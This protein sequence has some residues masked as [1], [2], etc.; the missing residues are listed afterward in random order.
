M[1]KLHSLIA[2]SISLCKLC[3][4]LVNS[5]CSGNEGNTFI[6]GT[7]PLLSFKLKFSLIIHCSPVAFTAELHTMVLKFLLLCLHKYVSP[8]HL[9]SIIQSVLL[10]TMCLMKVIP[11]YLLD[12][13]HSNKIYWHSLFVLCLFLASVSLYA[14][15]LLLGRRSIYLP[16]EYLIQLYKCNSNACVTALRGPAASR[17]VLLELLFTYQ[18]IFLH[19]NGWSNQLIFCERYA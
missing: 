6:T 14:F 1:E 15:L 18:S 9:F 8:I 11:S 7:F 5:R 16:F 2:R 4:S 17:L 19:V 12:S 13:F 10:L 3:E